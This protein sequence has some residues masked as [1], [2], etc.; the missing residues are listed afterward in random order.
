MINKD[1]NI[2]ITGGA[3]YIGSHI[4]EELVKQKNN[5]FILDNLI[6]GFKELI[7]KKAIFIKGDIKNITLVKKIIKKNNI[8]SII[9]LAAYLNVSEAEKNKKKY[10]QNNIKG[11]FNIIKACENSNVR[12]IIFSSSCSVYGNVKGSVSERK[13][14]NP[15]GYYAYTKY[16]G[17]EI[18]KK[19]AKKYNYKYAIL[20]YFN[21]VGASE[22]G[23]IGEIEI[24][25]NHLFKN[26]AA[27]S[28]KKNP[29]INIFGDNYNT[30]DGSCIRDYMH[31]VDLANIHIESLKKIKLSKKSI[32]LNCGY[33]KGISVIQVVKKFQNIIKR[34]VTINYNN[35]RP[36]DVG[37]VYACTRKL[38]K[39]IR[40]RPKYNSLEVMLKSA[41]KWEKKLKFRK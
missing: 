6:T 11:T 39:L 37:Q 16:K 15:Q 21:V 5:V 34:N 33:G 20:R 7:N 3:G 10:S 12:S 8:N 13:K 25:H 17:E 40:W 19:N 23:K 27:S 38:K 18:I 9:H 14:L 41:I 32:I 30:K 36:G 31:V 4:V 28:L 26:I 35:P 2:L 1:N 22:S 24:S 29:I